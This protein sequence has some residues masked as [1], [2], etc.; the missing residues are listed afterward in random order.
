MDLCEWIYNELKLIHNFLEV[1]TGSSRVLSLRCQI[2]EIAC[3]YA[4]AWNLALFVAEV[5]LLIMKNLSFI[6]WFSGPTFYIN[7]MPGEYHTTLHSLYKAKQSPASSFIWQG[8]CLATAKMLWSP[9][10]CQDFQVWISNENDTPA[11][12]KKVEA[13]IFSNMLKLNLWCDYMILAIFILTKIKEFLGMVFFFWTVL[14][15]KIHSVFQLQF[16]RSSIF[17][18][19]CIKLVTQN[20]FSGQAR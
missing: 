2:W 16:F 19:I 4:F 5:I 1:V 9:G 18:L 15:L 20:Y 11:F 13:S 17:Y 7:A 14:N 12:C 3:V 8:S 6:Q 10:S